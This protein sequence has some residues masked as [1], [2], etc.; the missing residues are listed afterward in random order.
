MKILA[1]R[2]WVVFSAAAIGVAIGLT[3]AAAAV[4][5]ASE[6][7]SGPPAAARGQTSPLS[8]FH[9]CDRMRGYLRRHRAALRTGVGGLPLGAED[10]VVGA[11]AAGGGP[12]PDPGSSTNVQEQGVDEPDLVKARGST[13]FAISGNR[14]RAVDVSAGA[15]AVVGSI[16]LPGAASG[17]YGD[18]ELLISGDRALVI[19][20]S[21]GFVG[22]P[23]PLAAD[24]Y[25]APGKTVL[26]EID[27]S[28]P[29]AMTEQSSMTADGDYV[30]ARLTGSTARIVLSAY[31]DIPVAQR[32]HGRA[33]MPEAVIHDAAGKATRRSLVDCRDVRRP[34]R[35]SGGE[36]LSV[37]T[38]DLDRGLPAIDADAV[39]TSGETVYASPTSLYVATERWAGPDAPAQRTSDVTTAIHRFDTS[40]PNA[41]TY[42]GS[43]TVDGYMLNQ[44]SMSEYQGILRVAS[45]TQPPW[46]QGDT[47]SPSQSFVTTLAPTGE[48]L[49][50]VGRLAGLGRG[51]QIYAVRFIDGSAY[52][53]TFRQVDP[54]YTV[55]LSDPTQPRLAGELKIPGYSAYLHP[56]GDGLLLGV[57]QDVSAAGVP[58]GAEAS[59]FDVSDPAAPLQV[60]RVSLGHESSTE[61]EYD[62]HAFTY[63]SALGLAVVPVES[64]S[65]PEFHGAVGIRVSAAGLGLTQ[66]TSIGDSYETAIRRSLVLGD[67][68]YTVSDRGVGEHDPQTLERLALTRFAGE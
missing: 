63:S 33:F 60:D 26:T 58:Q 57:G 20:R 31:P 24:L 19:S 41:T 25:A 8:A 64:Y 53:V 42:A 59:L 10:S 18:H 68:V 22:G 23:Q 39:L 9:S 16:E 67:H 47:Q 52:V 2:S 54:L 17:G 34:R 21:Y 27:I 61:V 28:D 62:H 36:M 65:G 45:T 40:D 4:L 1:I 66:P 6:S 29:A 5:G 43:G 35:F 46:E 38:V 51:E 14:L 48:R 44:W 37:L 32:G 3:I 56:V 15:P 49:T 11:P 30:S 12:A 13:I 50:E 55:D 7:R